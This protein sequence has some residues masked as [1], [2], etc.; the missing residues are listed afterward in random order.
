MS[1]KSLLEEFTMYD[2]GLSFND[3]VKRIVKP[4]YYKSFVAQILVF[5]HLASKYFLTITNWSTYNVVGFILLYFAIP[6]FGI[7][8]IIIE[9][10]FDCRYCF[11]N[12]TDKEK[13]K[14]REDYRK[15]KDLSKT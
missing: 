3:A 5:I 11:P 7:E 15:M 8:A 10:M 14:L 1:H 2:K 6:A 4:K 12:L 13:E 9:Y